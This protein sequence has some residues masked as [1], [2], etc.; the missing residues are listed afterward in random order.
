MHELRPFGRLLHFR[1]SHFLRL[2]TQGA[3]DGKTAGGCFNNATWRWNQQIFVKTDET[4]HAKIK[5]IQH[6]KSDPYFI[7][8]YL[9]KT[10]GS[11]KRQIKRDATDIYCKV[12][13]KQSKE[14][15]C[16]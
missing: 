12:G 3:W 2:A 1:I 6:T 10:D 15:T 7:G 9:I 14:S 16:S 13:F 11:G 5:L 8:F 4:K